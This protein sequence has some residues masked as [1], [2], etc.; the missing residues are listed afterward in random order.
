[1]TRQITH[2]SIHQTSK[3][4]ALLYFCFSLLLV[5]IAIG[6]MAASPGGAAWGCSSSSRRS[7]MG[8]VGYVGS[9][10]FAAIYN[11]LAKRVGGVEFESV[12]Q[13]SAGVGA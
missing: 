11:V 4:F 6:V 3:V 1:M 10:L 13:P 9:A 5:P 7:F 2:V 12:D 8:P